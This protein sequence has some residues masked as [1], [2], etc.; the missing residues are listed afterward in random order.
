MLSRQ[1]DGTVNVDCQEILL[2]EFLNQCELPVKILT[3]LHYQDRS[4]GICI[5]EF[6]PEKRL[7]NFP[8]EIFSQVCTAVKD[9]TDK[10]KI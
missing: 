6:S 3:P 7:K 10:C 2:D 9:C 5:R 4:F 1:A 8:N